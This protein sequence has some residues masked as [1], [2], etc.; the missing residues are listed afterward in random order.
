MLHDLLIGPFA[1]FEFMRRALVGTLVLSLSAC[2][3]GVFLM[4]RRMSLSGDAIAHSI[5]P[6]AAVGFLVSGLELLP[7]TFG[8]LVAGLA[9]ALLSGAVSRSTIQKEDASL[10]AF[11]LISL[12]LGVLLVSLK[13]S[14]V[15]LL[16]VLFGSVLALDDQALI[17]IGSIATATVLALAVAWRGLVAECLDPI[18]LRSVSGVGP[19]IHVLFLVLVVLNL[20]GGFEALG[21]LLSV[22]LMMLPAAAARFWTRRL[23]TMCALAVGFGALAS[24]TGLLVSYHASVASG[25]AI[26]LTAGIL[27]VL[28]LAFGRRGLI[29]GRL[30]TRHRTA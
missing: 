19:W 27:Y 26:V 28:S 23:E 10:A 21:T 16:H 5:L 3:V 29:A 14:S 30:S 24:V 22:G 11:Y 20:V 1:E 13:G 25:P 12:A 4:L 7:M 6:G 9:V 2:P 17:L 18:F 8:G 15:D